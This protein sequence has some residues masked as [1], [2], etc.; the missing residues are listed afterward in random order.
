MTQKMLVCALNDSETQFPVS[1]V[2]IASSCHLRCL[3]VFN[4]AII[5]GLGEHDN[6]RHLVDCW[7]V[8]N[9]KEL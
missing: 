7:R 6:V 9:S 5:L 8:H 1:L 2:L 3:Y 4:S